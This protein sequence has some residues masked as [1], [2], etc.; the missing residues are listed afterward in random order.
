MVPPISSDKQLRHIYWGQGVARRTG[1]SVRLLR[2]FLSP[3][4]SI[5]CISTPVCASLCIMI[6]PMQ[7]HA[8]V[9]ATVPQLLLLALFIWTRIHFSGRPLPTSHHPGQWSA[10]QHVRGEYLRDQGERATPDPRPRRI[11]YSRAALLATRPSRLDSHTT[12]TLRQLGVGYRLPRKSSRR[13]QRKHKQKQLLPRPIPVLVTP[14]LPPFY[15]PA[16]ICPTLYHSLYPSLQPTTLPAASPHSYLIQVPIST[17]NSKSNE[18]A[19][20]HFNAQSVGRT[21]AKLR[22]AIV[23]YILDNNLDMMFLSETWLHAR[24][25]E[26]ICADLTPNGYALRSFPRPSKGGGIAVIFRN[27]LGPNLSFSSSF[28]FTH[29]SFELVITSLAARGRTYQFVYPYR[30]PKSK[31]NQRWNNDSMFFE[32]FTSLLEFSNTL[33]GEAFIFGDINVHFDVPL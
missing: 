8:F 14:R 29:S 30:P 1:W 4:V 17:S 6:D 12:N 28:P 18:L 9:A 5:L 26:A 27:C 25:D 10:I 20:C 16:S 31:K 13:G 22:S 33:P 7:R 11:A 23:E 24:G 19:I 2:L 21:K 3:V 15:G 32:Q